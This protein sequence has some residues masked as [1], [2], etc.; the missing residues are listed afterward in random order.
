MLVQE[1][2]SEI[3]ISHEERTVLLVS[4]QEEC[5]N[6]YK[7]RIRDAENR[8]IAL[9]SQVSSYLNEIH[10]ISASLGDRLR[11]LSTNVGIGYFLVPYL[12]NLCVAIYAKSLRLRSIL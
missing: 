7:N 11:V 1:I 2:W 5:L 9:N 6:I 10:A 8:R 12:R 3:G 4:I